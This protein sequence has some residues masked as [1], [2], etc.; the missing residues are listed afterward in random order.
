MRRTAALP[1]VLTCAALAACG[2]GDGSEAAGRGGANAIA[3]PAASPSVNALAP[4][5]DGRTLL[6][7]TNRGLFR[8]RG[9][10][11]L[12]VPA[13]VIG[14][15]GASPVGARMIVAPDGRGGLL[16]S[17]H[18]DLSGPLPENLGLLRSADGGRTW[19]VVSDLGTGDYHVI[20]AAGPRVVAAD[21][22]RGTLAVS[23]DGGRTLAQRAI[24]GGVS[25][26]MAVDPAAPARVVVSTEEQLLRTEDAGRTWRPIGDVGGAHL[27]WPARGRLLLAR[28]DGAIL[29][30]RDAGRSFARVGRVPAGP[31][32]LLA[33]GARTAYVAL[34]DARILRSADGGRTWRTVFTPPAG[35]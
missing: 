31:E 19:R 8:V 34:A 32:R 11:A 12:R 30:S 15:T 4:A 3:D 35:G 29:A 28:P 5:G 9:G 33:A 20:H 26:D 16:G 17:G 1:A 6:L 10:R 13:Q 23:D 25:H 2:G 18:P 14:G 24:P 21:G 22:P 7:A 27:A